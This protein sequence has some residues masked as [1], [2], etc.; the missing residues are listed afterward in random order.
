MSTLLPSIPRARLQATLERGA[1]QYALSFRLTGT[2]LGSRRAHR[3]YSSASAPPTCSRSHRERSRQSCA[4]AL[5]PLVWLSTTVDDMLSSPIQRAFE[6]PGCRETSP[7][8]ISK[9]R[10]PDAR[11]SLPGLALEASRARSLVTARL[12]WSQTSIRTLLKRFDSPAERLRKQTRT[13]ASPV[14]GDECHRTARTLGWPSHRL[15][16]TGG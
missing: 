2:S 15:G 8:W 12:V 5:S 11:P 16:C 14:E 6:P 4:L 7:S 9:L 13:F 1:T 10:L 3:M